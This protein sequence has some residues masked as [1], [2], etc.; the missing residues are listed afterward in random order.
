MR[1]PDPFEQLLT[2]AY[3]ENRDAPVAY[4]DESYRAA[5]EHKGETPFYL[6]T[7]VIVF[8]SDMRVIRS[9]LEEIAGGHYWHTAE[10]LELVDGRVKVLEM[11]KYLAEGD[12]LGIITRKVD[13]DKADVDMEEARRTCLLALA[14]HLTAGDLDY[15][16]V[17]LMVLERR[18]TQSLVGRDQHTETLARQQALIPRKAKI[19][20]T[21]PRYE[22]LLW[23]PDVVSSAARK[24]QAMGD[25]ELMDVIRP[26]VKFINV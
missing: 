14:N 24:E 11:L 15:P 21:S 5:G 7:A 9:D 10:T 16:P 12:E 26:Q 19:L 4:L 23:L 13:V 6:F 17:S 3:N 1:R 20:Q 25:R 22:K 8:P 2:S 18:N